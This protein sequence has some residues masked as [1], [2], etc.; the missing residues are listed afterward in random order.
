LSQEQLAPLALEPGDDTDRTAHL[1]E[2]AACRAGLAAM[3]SRTR[4]LTEVHAKFNQ[5]NARFNGKIPRT[6]YS[7]TAPGRAA[8]AEYW[9]SLDQIRA[10]SGHAVKRRQS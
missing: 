4:Q 2:C 6:E 9:T 7:L 3:R 1:N 8:L 5:S 10:A